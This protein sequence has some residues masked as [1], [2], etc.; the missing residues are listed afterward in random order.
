MINSAKQRYSSFNYID[1]DGSKPFSSTFSSKWWTFSR[2]HRSDSKKDSSSSLFIKTKRHEHGEAF[3]TSG[4]NGWQES[5]VKAW[6]STQLQSIGTSLSVLM[7]R[8][9]AP[10]NQSP[11]EQMNYNTKFNKKV[12]L[13]NTYL[14]IWTQTS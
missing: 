13:N 1:C 9:S 2:F 4:L 14:I 10:P 11:G 12:K 6:M 3:N 7:E 8:V 5:Y